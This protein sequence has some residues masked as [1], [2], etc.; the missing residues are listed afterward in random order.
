MIRS[1]CNLWEIFLWFWEFSR[2][3]GGHY[4]IFGSYKNLAGELWGLRTTKNCHQ[5]SNMSPGWAG[6]G[7]CHSGV[8][9]IFWCVA[10]LSWAAFLNIVSLVKVIVIHKKWAKMSGWTILT[11]HFPNFLSLYCFYPSRSIF[12]SYVVCHVIQW[13]RSS[14]LAYAKSFW[15]NFTIVDFS[16]L[17]LDIN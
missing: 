15:F 6:A 12:L 16:F 14:L 17:I 13:S 9:G 8:T 11:C 4:H 10:W 5:C 1:Q 7:W 2:F 3:I